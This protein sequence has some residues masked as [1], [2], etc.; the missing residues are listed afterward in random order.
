MSTETNQSQYE[1]LDPYELDD[2]EDVS[3]LGD[4]QRVLRRSYKQPEKTY[5]F[6]T[7][8][9]IFFFVVSCVLCGTWYYNV[10]M[11]RNGALRQASFYSKS[12][13][14]IYFRTTSGYPMLTIY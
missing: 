5:L 8:I 3:F 14:C 1:P 13:V 11:R 6:I 4:K 10:H 9:N 2:N 12:L 7:A